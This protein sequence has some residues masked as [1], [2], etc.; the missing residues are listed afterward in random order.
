MNPP[1]RAA[2][3]LRPTLPEDLPALAAFFADRFGHPWAP[4]EWAWKY[5]ALPGESRSLVAV[6]ASV[7]VRVKARDRLAVVQVAAT[8]EAPAPAPAPEEKQA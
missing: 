5:R 2:P 8:R 4:E 3:T 6:D 7:Q 1:E